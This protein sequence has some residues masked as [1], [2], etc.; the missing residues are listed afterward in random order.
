MRTV[1]IIEITMLNV[2]FV[3]YRSVEKYPT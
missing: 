2:L 1:N 3:L